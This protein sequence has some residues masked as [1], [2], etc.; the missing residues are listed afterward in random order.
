[1]ERDNA[2]N[3]VMTLDSS[4]IASRAF[5]DSNAHEIFLAT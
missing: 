3:N 1:M 5:L 2:E 4:E